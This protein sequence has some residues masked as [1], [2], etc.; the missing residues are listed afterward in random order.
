MLRI[1]CLLCLVGVMSWQVLIAQD[2]TDVVR[3]RNLSY[4]QSEWVQG[5]DCDDIAD[6]LSARICANLAFQ[7]ADRKMNEQFVLHLEQIEN[8]SI[9][10]EVIN[11]QQAWVDHR[12]LQS[13]TAADGYRGHM[14]G[15]VYLDHMIRLT[16]W[17]MEELRYLNNFEN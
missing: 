3:L 7:E 17:R 5:T 14:L 16:E 1:Q 12:R 15:L 11:Y 13:H 10:Q 9:R 2:T 4:M 6:N 8:D